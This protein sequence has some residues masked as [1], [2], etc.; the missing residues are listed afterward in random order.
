MLCTPAVTKDRSKWLHSVSA[1]ELTNNVIT[2][3]CICFDLIFSSFDNFPCESNGCGKIVGDLEDWLVFWVLEVWINI[4][5][6][7]FDAQLHDLSPSQIY[8]QSRA[9]IMFHF[10]YS[11]ISLNLQL[12]TTV[13]AHIGV[14]SRVCSF[15]GEGHSGFATTLNKIANKII[16]H[17]NLPAAQP[18]RTAHLWITPC[19]NVL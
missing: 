10:N 2:V 4:N 12:S 7:H 14:A 18:C 6:V 5:Y 3:S 11:T 13:N 16:M 15:R 17:L 19:R 9:P 1:V 8:N